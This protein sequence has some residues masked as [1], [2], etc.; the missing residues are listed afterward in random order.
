MSERSRRRRPSGSLAAS[1][2]YLWAVASYGL[3][4]VE[5]L[6]QPHELRIKGGNL[7]VSAITAW[8]RTD[9]NSTLEARVTELEA[10]VQPGRQNGHYE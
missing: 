6:G 8:V 1:K 3:E 4:V 5:D 2:R 9:E 10:A 7:V